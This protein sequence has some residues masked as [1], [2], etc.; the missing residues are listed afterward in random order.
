M[1]R[2]GDAEIGRWGDGEMGDGEMG[3][4]RWEM[5]DGRW[6]M[7]DGRWEMDV[8]PCFADYPIPK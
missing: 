4:G 8:A 5:G 6:E 2:R 1:G 3:D 7:G